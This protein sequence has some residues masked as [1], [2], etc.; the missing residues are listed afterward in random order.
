MTRGSTHKKTLTA[1]LCVLFLF[2]TLTSASELIEEYIV[3]IDI[4]KDSSITILE[5]ITYNFGENRRRGIFRE[6]PVK[7][8]TTVGKRGVDL[9]V[10]S[11]SRDGYVE[12]YTERNDGGNRVVKIGDP[13]V[14][15]SGKHVYRITYN[16]EGA[17]NSFEEYDELY[18]N[19][20]G[21]G[22]EFPIKESKV[23]VRAPGEI[24]S[25]AC[26][27]GVLGV[28]TECRNT[29]IG[30]SFFEANVID[31]APYNGVTIAVALPKQTV[32]VPGF[33][34]RLFRVVKNN[35]ILLL[36]IIVLAAMYNVWDTKGRDAKGRGT[37]I[38]QYEPQAGLTPLF[39]GSIV[40]G[41]LNTHDITAGIVYLAEQGYITIGRSEKKRFLG[42][43]IDYAMTWIGDFDEL[44][45][46]EQL[47]VALLFGE[48][49]FKGETV[50][51]SDLKKDQSL[52]RKRKELIAY[53][54][55]ELKD[56]GYFASSPRNTRMKWLAFG[57]SILTA[58]SYISFA[59]SA[60]AGV[61][62]FLSGLV[63][64][65]FGIFMPKL[66]KKGALAREHILGFKKFMN[67]AEKERLDFHN[68]PERTNHEFMKNLPF[69]IALGVEKKWAEQFKG[70]E[71]VD[72]TWYS[73]GSFGDFNPIVFASDMTSFDSSMKAGVTAAQG[74]SGTSGGGFSGGGVGGGGGG[75]W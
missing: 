20:I 12:D 68:A 53:I 57:T 48:H 59:M 73:G 17:F 6:I 50:T 34:E 71:M 13:D 22:W 67:V 37:I 46:K 16:V 65:V 58:L 62:V 27:E 45:K 56:Q 3:D 38:P 5:T 60:V 1:F 55:K 2:P 21:S 54:D 36:P 63:I 42:S 9:E 19:A 25:A 49:V 24:E 18:W 29:V 33:L 40:D 41:T 43:N 26:Y 66:T 28:K 72:P 11:V 8:E 74:G 30:G 39:L 51:L 75:S 15:I 61:A 70:L 69:A 44:N 7:Y 47:V 4:N 10:V 14:Y 64:V 32:T 35:I 23:T 52:E 31:L